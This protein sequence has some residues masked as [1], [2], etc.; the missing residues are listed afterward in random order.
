MISVVSLSISLSIFL[1]MYLA[2]GLRSLRKRSS[3]R[4]MDS[5][6]AMNATEHTNCFF[7]RLYLLVSLG[8]RLLLIF[9]RFFFNFFKLFALVSGD[10]VQSLWRISALLLHVIDTDPLLVIWLLRCSSICVR[11]IR[12][13][14]S[15]LSLNLTRIDCI[16]W[17]VI[18]CHW[19]II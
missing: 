5:A 9:W 6:E 12:S 10:P 14:K 8:F 18:D 19:L 11:R 4:W 13:I 17:K 15:Q 2:N 16:D 7:Y 3:Q 1:S